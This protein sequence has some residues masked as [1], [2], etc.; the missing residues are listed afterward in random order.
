[1][2]FASSVIVC[3]KGKGLVRRLLLMRYSST[4]LGDKMPSACSMSKVNIIQLSAKHQENTTLATVVCKYVVSSRENLADL[5]VCVVGGG[6]VSISM[7]SLSPVA[8]EPLA[9]ASNRIPS[10]PLGD[11]EVG[12]PGRAVDESVLRSK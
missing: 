5:G 4:H 3:Y 11:S 12:V 8:E 7:P 2:K 10:G 1:M 9:L 6:S